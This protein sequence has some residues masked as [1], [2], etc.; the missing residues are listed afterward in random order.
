MAATDKDLGDLHKL[1]ADSLAEDLAAADAIEDPVLRAV[2]RKDARA[3]AIAFL[4]NNNI[5]ADPTTDSVL[6]SLREKLKARKPVAKP[7]LLE[8]A[9]QFAARNG[10]MLQ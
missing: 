8:A 6:L 5:T 4:K 3:Q 9:E 10:D 7:A 2:A 1:V